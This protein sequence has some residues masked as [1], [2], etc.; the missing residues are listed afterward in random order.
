MRIILAFLIAT[1]ASASAAMDVAAIRQCAAI[2]NDKV[3]LAC[4]DAAVRGTATR[5]KTPLT[6]PDQVGK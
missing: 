4:Y 2:Q 5:P 1:T 3:R 6:V